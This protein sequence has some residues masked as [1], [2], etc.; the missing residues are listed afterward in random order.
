MDRDEFERLKE[1]EKAH[2]RKVRV[3][4]Q[5]LREAKR[6]QG[7]LGA[8]QGLDTSGLD[9][10]HEEMLRKVTEKNVTAEARFELAMEALD[11]AEKQEATREEMARIEAERQKTAAADLVRQMKAQMLGD[12]AE[13][14]EAQ[15][16]TE[17][18]APTTEA[19]SAPPAKTIGPTAGPDDADPAGEPD[20]G[21]ADDAPPARSIG[22][23]GR[24]PKRD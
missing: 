4:K 7:V 17:R 6:K 23:F 16:P 24:D 9:A 21:R 5:Q 3:L 20:A 22:R 1:E 15:Q 13:H 18:L 12:A 2:L 11:E 8:L 14:V 10:T 19:P